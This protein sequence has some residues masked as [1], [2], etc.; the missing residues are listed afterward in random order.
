MQLSRNSGRKKVEQGFTLLEVLVSVVIVSLVVTV[1]FQLLSSGIKLE[2]KSRH[3]IQDLLHA[4]QQ[5]EDLLQED[6]RSDDFKWQGSGKTFNWVLNIEPVEIV[7]LEE[8]DNATI[9]LPGELYRFVFQWKSQESSPISLTRYVRYDLNF[10]SH[11]F[12]E[13]HFTKR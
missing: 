6:M 8:T 4:Q 7:Q 2:Y 5:F 10:L 11:E 9:Q 13:T 1:F 12:K 3:K